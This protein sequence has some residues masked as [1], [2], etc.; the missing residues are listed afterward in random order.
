MK[1]KIAGNIKGE[2]EINPKVK[3]TKSY[4]DFDYYLG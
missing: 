1:V 2:I 4:Y 3:L